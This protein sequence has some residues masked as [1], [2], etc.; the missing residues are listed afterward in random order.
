M[1]GRDGC[2][3]AQG[4]SQPSWYLARSLGAL[5]GLSWAESG[6]Y[7]GTATP[8]E[9]G[10][11]PRPPPNWDRPVGASLALPTALPLLR[12]TLTLPKPQSTQKEKKNLSSQP[13][14]PESWGAVAPDSTRQKENERLAVWWVQLQCPT[15]AAGTALAAAAMLLWQSTRFPVPPAALPTQKDT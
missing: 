12:G 13:T 1:M 8:T 6:G 10:E 11:D 15:P 9:G 3:R 7:W 4:T 2:E 5:I 14:H